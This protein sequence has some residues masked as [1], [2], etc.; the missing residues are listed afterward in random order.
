LKS[1]NTNSFKLYTGR[2]IKHHRLKR[3]ITQQELADLLNVDRQYVW[4]IENGKINLTLDYLDKIVLKLKCNHSDF[5][6]NL[7]E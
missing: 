5:L 2:L 7:S 6:K 3:Q 1:T 4:K